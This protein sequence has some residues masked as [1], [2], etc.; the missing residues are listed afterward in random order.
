MLYV[1]LSLSL[2]L[3]LIANR[4]AHRPEGWREA[5]FILGLAFTFV[6]SCLGMFFLPPVALL[7]VLLAV[8]ILLWSACGLRPWLFV[9]VSCAVAAAAFGASGWYALAEYREHERLRRENPVVSLEGRL[10][11]VQPAFRLEHLPEAG[12]L[13]LGR[14]EESVEM[15]AAQGR[16]PYYLRMLHESTVGLFVNSPGFGVMRMSRPSRE[17]LSYGLRPPNRVSQPEPSTSSA[18]PAEEGPWEP[19]A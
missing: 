12:A 7:F 9:P 3:L 8:A 18:W 14:L 6:P 1:S 4:A 5:F 19:R 2:V 13:R 10:P 17:E 16:R 11:T 15:E